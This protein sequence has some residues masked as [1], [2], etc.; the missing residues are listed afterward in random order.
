LLALVGLGLVMTVARRLLAGQRAAVDGRCRA[1]PPAL[2]TANGVEFITIEDKI[3][4]ANLIVSPKSANGS[5]GST[6]RQPIAMQPA[7]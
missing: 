3:G 5:V 2:G 6:R 7:C 4:I 1:D